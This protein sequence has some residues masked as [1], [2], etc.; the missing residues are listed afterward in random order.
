MRIA[1]PQGAKLY[2]IDRNPQVIT[3]YYAAFN[4]GPLSLTQVWSYTVPMGRAFIAQFIFARQWVVAQGDLIN[5]ATIFIGIPNLLFV[6]SE[7]WTDSK[8]NRQI[9][10]LPLQTHFLSEI[11]IVAHF[12]IGGG[13]A[14]FQETGMVGLEYDR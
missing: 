2:P 13:A 8:G 4:T 3:K 5:S 10:D 14:V 6:R 1:V 7:V 9:V 11:Q 12:Q